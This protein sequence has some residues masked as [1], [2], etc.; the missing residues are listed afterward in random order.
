MVA[1]E[2]L[3]GARW[4]QGR[5]CCDA[6]TLVRLGTTFLGAWSKGYFTQHLI[7]F[8]LECTKATLE[9]LVHPNSIGLPMPMKPSET[10]G[11]PIM[12]ELC[13]SIIFLC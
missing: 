2:V 11:A 7:S 10:L 1:A 12:C 5:G 13:V 9:T 4:Q 3:Q 8:N 6:I